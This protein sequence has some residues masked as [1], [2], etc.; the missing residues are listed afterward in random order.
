MDHQLRISCAAVVA[1][2]DPPGGELFRHRAMV[3]LMREDGE[4]VREGFWIPEVGL[5]PNPGVCATQPWHLTG[6]AGRWANTIADTHRL[7]EPAWYEKYEVAQQ[8]FR[9]G[10]GSIGA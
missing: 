5:A 10:V 2:P 9:S 3:D 8:T 1:G 4:V 7:R 6:T